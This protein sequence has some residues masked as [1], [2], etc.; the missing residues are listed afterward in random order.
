MTQ[1][2]QSIG[3]DGTQ[4]MSPLWAE[5]IDVKVISGKIDEESRRQSWGM[6]YLGEARP[7]GS[8]P[9]RIFPGPEGRKARPQVTAQTHTLT[10]GLR[11]SS[12]AMSCA[13]IHKI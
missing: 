9:W 11:G 4:E 8:H 12:V 2:S 6:W 10:H 7:H 1:N 5:T 13:T 3:T